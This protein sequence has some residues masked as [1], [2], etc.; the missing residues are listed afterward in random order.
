MQTANDAAHTRIEF[1]GFE[2][3]PGLRCDLL[4]F[5]NVFCADMTLAQAR[6][7]F[8]DSFPDGSAPLS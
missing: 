8:E 5:L 2:E 4:A 3:W 1:D 7:W 6:E